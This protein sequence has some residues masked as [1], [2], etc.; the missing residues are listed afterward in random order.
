MKQGNH[1]S[2]EAAAPVDSELRDYNILSRTSGMGR[3]QITL[4]CPCCGAEV[5]AY[6]WSLAGSGKRCS[7]GALHT[8]YGT[9]PRQKMPR[10]VVGISN[11]TKARR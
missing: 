10:L 9:H 7:C 4:V 11:E 8:S 3:T 1:P 6:V 2:P 5:T